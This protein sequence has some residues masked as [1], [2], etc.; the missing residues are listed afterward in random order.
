MSFAKEA[1]LAVVGAA[2]I[3][4][5]VHQFGSWSLNAFYIGISLLTVVVRFSDHRGLKFA[6]RKIRRK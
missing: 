2:W 3:V 6:L 4:G 1:I 5:L